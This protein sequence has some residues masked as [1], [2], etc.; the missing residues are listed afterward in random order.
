MAT[1]VKQILE[2]FYYYIGL[3]IQQSDALMAKYSATYA[4]KEPKGQA[5]MFVATH[6]PKLKQDQALPYYCNH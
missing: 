2:M 6:V 3:V 5:R 1:F 4:T